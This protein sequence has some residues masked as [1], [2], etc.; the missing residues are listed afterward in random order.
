MQ[1]QIA[2]QPSVLCCH[3]ANT[4]EEF[5][6]LATAILP[7]AQLHWSLFWFVNTVTVNLVSCVAAVKCSFVGTESVGYS[8]VIQ[9]IKRVN[10]AYY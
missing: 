9:C 8:D 10:C 1:L 5:G 6:G 4:N 7:F 3:L 2:A